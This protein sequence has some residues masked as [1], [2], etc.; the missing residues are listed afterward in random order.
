M[1]VAA[2]LFLA[3]LCWPPARLSRAVVS[4]AAPPEPSR[5]WAGSGA[6]SPLSVGSSI[7][8]LRR[9]HA[10]APA[11]LLPFLDALAAALRVGLPT[12]DAVRSAG[13]DAPEE[14]RR[15]VVRPVLEAAA[16][17]RPTAG[18][19]Q[20]CARELGSS[21]L[22]AVARAVALSEQLGAPLAEGVGAAAAGVRSRR[23]LEQRLAAA[24][25]GATAT[26]TV[27]SALPVAGV[28]LAALLGVPPT[29]LYGTAP[30]Q[31]SLVLGLVLLLVGRAG[32]RRM[33][34]GVRS[35]AR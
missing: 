12:A 4:V 15:A 16:G 23:R 19:W 27:L 7:A 31:A 14:L 25:A 6:R 13:A 3:V 21:H 2:L 29:Q 35:R 20:R 22:H 10:P 1:I 33:V 18:A 24:T 8:W 5:E 28:A 32:V 11:E 17:G 30:A 34:S 9:S 26:G